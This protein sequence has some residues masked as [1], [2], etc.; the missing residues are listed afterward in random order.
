MFDPI[1]GRGPAVVCFFWA[2]ALFADASLV[3]CE[4]SGIREKS[5]AKK[6][7][8]AGGGARGGSAPRA[9]SDAVATAM[10]RAQHHEAEWRQGGVFMTLQKLRIEARCQGTLMASGR[11]CRNGAFTPSLYAV[12]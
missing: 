12:E 4:R 10:S 2:D 6:P 8:L 9:G 3:R 11:L 5:L 7:S 1:T